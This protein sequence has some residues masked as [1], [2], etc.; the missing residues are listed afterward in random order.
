MGFSRP[1]DRY[2]AGYAFFLKKT[3]GRKPTHASRKDC[4]TGHIGPDTLMPMKRLHVNFSG[5]VHGVGFRYTTVSL[6]S[7]L[8]ITGWVK[9]LSD[10]S[11]EIVAEAPQDLLSDLLSRLEREFGGYIKE[12]KISWES[13]TGEFKEFGIRF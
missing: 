9:N 7:S 13:A 3:G 8:G 5:H 11:V 10:G 12:K 1:P 2:Q 6:A 4:R